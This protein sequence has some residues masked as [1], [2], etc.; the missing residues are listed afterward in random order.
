MPPAHAAAGRSAS[1]AVRRL[2]LIGVACLLPLL[3]FRC[4]DVQYTIHWGDY[5]LHVERG[6]TVVDLDA[7]VA[8][9]TFVAQLSHPDGAEAG[10]Q[11]W[12]RSKR[13]DATLT[14]GALRFGA[15]PPGTPVQSL[16]EIRI[17]HPLTHLP[18]PNP[19]QFE[20][21]LLD[22]Y[23]GFLEIETTATGRFRVETIDGVAWI[24]T[25]DGHGQF[26]V[27]PNTVRYGGDYSPPIGAAPYRDHNDRVYGSEA[28][29]AEVAEERIRGW[30]FPT[31]GGWTSSDLLRES[32]PHPRHLKFARHAPAIPIPQTT[33]YNQDLRDYFDPA[34]AAGAATEAERADVCAA[35][36]LCIGV[37]TDNELPWG[38]FIYEAMPYLDAY[39]TLPAGAPGKLALQDYLES[40][41]GDVENFNA[42]WDQA[43]ASFDEVQDLAGLPA[44]TTGSPDL[45]PPDRL[46]DRR[47][48]MGIVAGR[49]FEVVHDALRAAHPDVLILGARFVTAFTGLEA[50]RAAGPWV[51]VLSFNNYDFDPG[52]RLFLNGSG[53]SYYEN[54]FTAFGAFGGLDASAAVAPGVPMMVTEWF[55]RV[56]LPGRQTP[57][58]LPGVPG[59]E[60][61]PDAVENYLVEL[62]ERPYMVG[63]H[64]HQYTDQPETGRGD[65]E[66]MII[67]LV[68]LED[69]P[70]HAMMERMTAVHGEILLRRRALAGRP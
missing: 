51:D 66:N 61:R 68:D 18:H 43:I 2:L 41:Y 11:V 17:R 35:D 34:F 19:G 69:E 39:A 70:H 40:R 14:D 27:A 25:P 62:I 28:A 3:G 13:G 55:Y 7:L 31:L 53:G 54:P 8:E 5:V 59:F 10:L 15:L 9:T 67:G 37:F 26:Q 44:L 65:G 64:W 50:I 52:A 1:L 48:F 29:W 60:D 56:N 16:D 12:A 57:P 63:A 22:R 36:P 32:L 30:L 58:T 23:G 46:A 42:A 6:E 47:A 21:I 24:I 20:W 4:D 33:P 45:A 38:S 49:Y